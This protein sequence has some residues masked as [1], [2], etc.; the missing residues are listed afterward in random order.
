MKENKNE[1]PEQKQNEDCLSLGIILDRAR[2]EVGA[3]VLHYMN[4]SGIPAS[5][6][7]YVLAD[8]VSKVK[9]LKA[10]EYTAIIGR[11]EENGEHTEPTE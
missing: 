9:E 1:K 11:G 5:I 8:I 2:D 3:M 4:T 10:S 7:D 6:F